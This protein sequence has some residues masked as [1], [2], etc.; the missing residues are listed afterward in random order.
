MSFFL[1]SAGPCTEGRSGGGGGCEEEQEEQEESLFSLELLVE[2]ARVE[3]RLLPTPLPACG[4]FR[5]AV[6]LRL[7]D[8]PTLLVRAPHA[9]RGPVVPFGR[10]K[11]CLFRLR[12]GALRDLLRRSPLYALLLALPPTPGAAR[13]LGSCSVS[14]AAAAEELWQGTGP[15]GRRGQFPL[16]DLMGEQ[17]GELGLSYRLTNLGVTLLGH[18]GE[19]AAPQQPHA[20]R[21]RRPETPHTLGATPG[22]ARA[23]LELIPEGD[24]DQE[25]ASETG[26]PGPLSSPLRERRLHLPGLEKAPRG[27]EMEANVFCPPPMFYTCPTENPHP[28]PKSL[29]PGI[30]TVA[31]AQDSFPA[32]EEIN[33]PSPEPLVKEE[34]PSTGEEVPPSPQTLGSPEELRQT[35]N[36]LPLLN[37]LL[38]ELSLLNKQPLCAQPFSVHPQLVW[39]YKNAEEGAKSPPPIAKSVGP[40]QEEKKTAHRKERG[41]SV[42]PKLKRNH[43]D[44]LKCISPS[45]QVTSPGMLKVHEKREHRRK[46]QGDTVI[47]KKGKSSSAKGKVL[48]DSPEQYAK[49]AGHLDEKGIPEEKV[50]INENV[51]TL[52]QS[53]AHQDC[54]TN[55]KLVAKAVKN[56]ENGKPNTST[57]VVS[58][59]CKEKSLKVHLPR[60]FLQDA[61]THESKISTEVVQCVPH[62]DSDASATH[63][64]SKSKNCESSHELK[65]LE[66][67]HANTESVAY[68]EDFTSD[69]NSSTN[70]EAQESSPEPVLKNPEPMAEN[71]DQSQSIVE[72]SSKMSEGSSADQ[73]ISNPLPVPS[74]VSPVQYL[75]KTHNLKLNGKKTMVSFDKSI[76]DSPPARTL[77]EGLAMEQI[78]K[79][80]SKLEQALEKTEV[81]SDMKCSIANDLSV[82]NSNSLRTSQVSSYLPSNMSDLDLSDSEESH[83]PEKEKDD[84]EIVDIANQCKHVSEL[85]V[86]KL[87]GYT[88]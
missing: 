44:H 43:V 42:S 72:P 84:F 33:V 37:A 23:S 66:E 24:E 22:S 81:S 48:H 13:L 65:S 20:K 12:P 79:E 49:S 61:E 75:E 68:S 80:R 8:F 16:Q 47:E 7:L 25:P 11:S 76:D 32:A 14:L 52:I 35:L 27:L 15:G 10:G 34:P 21:E 88:M 85:L 77:K 56:S 57:E 60:V 64:D 28:K 82:E 3:A 50:Q 41:R 1:P 2:S 70:W 9:A 54:P 19:G 40:Y 63:E 67:G 55:K 31:P 5:P 39:L 87:P 62:S 58:S 29:A 83:T 36:Q 6:A 45:F 86:N 69:D 73:S 46:K 17:V 30:V 74:A 51:E 18:L 53:S 26:S 78:R 38:V 71:L 59:A 4:P